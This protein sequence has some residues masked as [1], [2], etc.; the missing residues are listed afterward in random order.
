MSRIWKVLAFAVA[1]VVIAT[2][3][4]V[5]LAPAPAERASPGDTASYLLTER[6]SLMDVG[7]LRLR[8][9]MATLEQEGKRSFGFSYSPDEKR[10]YI[11]AWYHMADGVAKDEAGRI[12]REGVNEVRKYFCVRD[13]RPACQGPVSSAAGEFTHHHEQR[14]TPDDV[15]LKVDQLLYVREIV[16]IKGGGHVTCIGKLVGKDIQLDP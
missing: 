16:S 11:A 4:A 9:S 8:Q 15:A 7:L 10:I 6:A 1:A 3:I 13:G 14:S 12:C 2:G 5:W